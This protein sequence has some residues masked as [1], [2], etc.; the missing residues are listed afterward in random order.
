MKTKLIVGFILIAGVITLLF[1]KGDSVLVSKPGSSTDLNTVDEKSTWKKA[2][3][4]NLEFR[5]PATLTT[6]YVTPNEWPLD[7]QQETSYSCVEGEDLLNGT[8]KTEKRMIQGHEYC[9]TTKNEGAAG[10]IYS[11][12]TYVTQKDGTTLSALVTMRQ[13]QCGNYDGVEQNACKAE[14]QNFNLDQLLHEIIQTVTITQ[15]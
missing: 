3:S 8:G 7:I 12:Y 15:S 9:I 10:S 14:Q 2:R 13:V 11:E 4:G 6:K 1:L 5:Y